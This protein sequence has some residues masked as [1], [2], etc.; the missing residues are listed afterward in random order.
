MLTVG[1][2]L[3]FLGAAIAVIFAGAGS[4]IGVSKAGQALAGVCAEKPER[5]SKCLILQLLPATQ[6]LYGFIIAFLIVLK[7]GVLSGLQPITLE[8][9]F[10]LVFGAMPIGFVGFFSAVYQGKVAAAGIMM[11]G[12]HPETSGRAMT[13]T[14]IVEM[15]AIF[16]LIIS[17]FLCFIGIT[18]AA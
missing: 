13:S 18:I 17:F 5:F 1:H 6:G 2:Y 12:K 11:V 9:G 14:A 7:M 8:Q 3:G 10:A 15:Y 16:A 4:A